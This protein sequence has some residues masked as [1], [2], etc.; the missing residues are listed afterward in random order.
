MKFETVVLY[1]GKPI[2]RLSKQFVLNA[3]PVF[4]PFV[5]WLDLHEPFGNQC[6]Q[7]LEYKTQACA[8]SCRWERVGSV[9][10]EI[11][12]L[13]GRTTHRNQ[14]IHIFW[15]KVAR[16]FL[17]DSC[18]KSPSKPCSPSVPSEIWEVSAKSFAQFLKVNQHWII[19]FHRDYQLKHLEWGCTCLVEP[20]TMQ[21]CGTIYIKQVSLESCW[22]SQYSA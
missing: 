16:Y 6:Q 1:F 11:S 19:L 7:V 12:V 18:F 4:K 3:N 17:A 22:L 2:C 10:A 13:Q 14:C 8:R 21:G 15:F 20:P 9:D 5:S